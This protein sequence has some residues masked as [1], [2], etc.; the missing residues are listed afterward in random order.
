MKKKIVL[1][2]ADVEKILEYRAEDVNGNTARFRKW[3]KGGNCR[4]Y[5]QNGAFGLIEFN[6]KST[7]WH[8][9]MLE[10][11]SNYKARRYQ[12]CKNYIDLKTNELVSVNKEWP[13]CDFF[14]E[15]QELV[16]NILG[17]RTEELQEDEYL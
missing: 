8:N 12:S 7:G 9:V 1:T 16:N 2:E 14:D 4:L 3:E 13:G 6:T 11:C 10:G 17:I 15:L 5:I